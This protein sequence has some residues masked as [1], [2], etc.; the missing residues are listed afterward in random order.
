[1]DRWAIPSNAMREIDE[2]LSAAANNNNTASA[3]A[4]ADARAS[5]ERAVAQLAQAFDY[6]LLVD[7][8]FGHFV[9]LVSLRPRCLA[10]PAMVKAVSDALVSLWHRTTPEEIAIV[11]VRH[12]VR[13]LQEAADLVDCS[14]AAASA[15]GGGG[16]GGGVAG[17]SG[18]QQQQHLHD[19]GRDERDH[20]HHHSNHYQPNVG[21]ADS[22][23]LSAYTFT[24]QFT[25]PIIAALLD[26]LA[27]FVIPGQ[28]DAWFERENTSAATAAVLRVFSLVEP[29]LLSEE[30]VADL[31][32]VTQAVHANVA[33][34]VRSRAGWRVP[35]ALVCDLARGIV[36]RKYV[37]EHFEAL[38]AHAS[39]SH[40][41]NTLLDSGSGTPMP[42]SLCRRLLNDST[43]SP[44]EHY[45]SR[46]PAL[47]ALAMDGVGCEV[48]NNA[49]HQTRGLFSLIFADVLRRFQPLI[50]SCGPHTAQVVHWA[51]AQPALE[52]CLVFVDP[53][54]CDEE[55]IAPRR[56]VAYTEAVSRWSR[57]LSKLRRYEEEVFSNAS[58]PVRGA[59][60]GSA[61]GAGAAPA[62]VIAGSRGR[63]GGGGGGGGGSPSSTTNGATTANNSSCTRR[64][65]DKL[66][67]LFELPELCM[68]ANPGCAQGSR[69]NRV[70]L[71][72]NA[73]VAALRSSAGNRAG[74]LTREAV[75][76]SSLA[77]SVVVPEAGLAGARGDHA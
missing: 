7:S 4:G 36:A 57:S 29:E 75:A 28:R 37:A 43:I 40:V 63:G 60:C 21:G 17:G 69:C 39:G 62:G 6:V 24:E 68:E 53:A 52:D 14:K 12:V 74:V 1:M 58:T 72:S 35:A 18:Q 31:R 51:Q 50:V 47:V 77:L 59:S 45:G 11:G 23:T 56:L 19:A 44:I 10:A 27:N 46:L 32:S 41:V 67:S 54:R 49:L 9:H 33:Q 70:H 20:H 15:I 71:E 64:W 48:M 42:R 55:C 5:L 26:I 61:A 13:F 76:R 30:I 34:L 3:G 38:A 66:Q 25:L 73:D 22:E 2:L 16:D 65:M 8:L